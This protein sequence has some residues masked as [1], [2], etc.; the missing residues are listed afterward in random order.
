MIVTCIPATTRHQVFWYS[1]IF[2]KDLSHRLGGQRIS[3]LYQN[4]L[5]RLGVEPC[6]LPSAIIPI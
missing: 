3:C 4:K 2:Y 5:G 1:R 6:N